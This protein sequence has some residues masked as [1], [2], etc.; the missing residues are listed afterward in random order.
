MGHVQ[1]RSAHV[2]RWSQLHA[3]AVTALLIVLIAQSCG[4]QA[5]SSPA[6]PPLETVACGGERW[7]VKTLSD[8]A[9]TSVNLNAAQA[10]TI[11]AL[12]ELPTHCSGLPATRAF[13]E[14]FV[15]YEVVGRITLVRL[16]DDHDYHVAVVDP[17]DGAYTMV[18]EV[19]DVACE[20][21]ASSPFMR[22]LGSVRQSFEQ[23]FAGRSPSSLVGTTV[24]VRG[25]GFYDFDHGQTGRS[26]N[27]LELHPVVSVV[28]VPG[29]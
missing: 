29:S 11:R 23:L 6:A 18:T 2:L 7:A 15:L 3:F 4:G 5:P 17:S 14:E 1:A 8:A 26:R 21:A 12:N 24:R 25:V 9:A 20:G 13:A 16:E 28:R 22:D 19:P 10:T 27:C